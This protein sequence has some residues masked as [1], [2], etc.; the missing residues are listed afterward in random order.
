MLQLTTKGV[1]LPRAYPSRTNFMNTA[2]ALGL[3]GNLKICLDFGD[4]GCYS[5]SGQNVNDLSANA[6][7][8]YRGPT[9]GAEGRDP[10]FNGTAGTLSSSEYF[11]QTGTQGLS[12][13]SGTNPAWVHNLHKDNAKFTFITWITGPDYGFFSYLLCSGQLVPGVTWGRTSAELFTTR[14]FGDAGST[15]NIQSTGSVPL[16]GWVCMAVSL[17]EAV[18]AN[19]QI[20]FINGSVNLLTSTYS[21]PSTADAGQVLTLGGAN[22]SAGNNHSGNIAGFLIYEGVALSQ[23]QLYAFYNA[24]R[25]RFGV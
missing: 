16:T 1:M 8:F 14:V 22:F 13:Q 20:H 6:H 12:L 25:W 17:D 7:H 15:V 19:G 24:T 10:T 23:A 5:G 11:S 21:S 9:S 18:G 3:A 2:Y 4:A